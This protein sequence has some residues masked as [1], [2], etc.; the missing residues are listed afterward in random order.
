MGYTLEAASKRELSASNLLS[1]SLWDNI[2]N[3]RIYMQ[4]KALEERVHEYRSAASWSESD[5]NK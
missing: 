3:T 1:Q 2:K 4:K 5:N